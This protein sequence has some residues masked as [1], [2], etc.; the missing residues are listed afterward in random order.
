MR[1]EYHNEMELI[2]RELTNS[3]VMVLAT[4]ASNK[5]TVRSI[6]TIYN[7]GSIYF[8]TDKNME[9]CRQ[10]KVN[11]NV[12]LTVGYIQIEGEASIVGA[13]DR[14][15]DLLNQYIKKHKQSYER[16][17]NLPTEIVVKVDIT[18]V[19]KWSYVDNVPYV[20][21]IYPQDKKITCS[22]YICN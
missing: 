21:E 2:S 20:I 7:N 14:H 4:S 8:Q 6:C 9:K 17:K 15:L 3:S 19:K 10:I 5:V 22:E 18:K 1:V 13:W 12:A 16:Y 11:K